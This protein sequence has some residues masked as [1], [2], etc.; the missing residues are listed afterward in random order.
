LVT[1]L[2]TLVFYMVVGILFRPTDDNPYLQANIG[3]DDVDVVEFE[4]SG[5]REV[6]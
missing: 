5:T 1:E 3:A 6:L 2:A 4:F